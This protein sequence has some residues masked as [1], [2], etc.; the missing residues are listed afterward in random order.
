MRNH[1]KLGVKNSVNGMKN[2]IEGTHS[3]VCKMKDGISELQDRN[4]K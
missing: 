1:K 2:V 3:R 4:L